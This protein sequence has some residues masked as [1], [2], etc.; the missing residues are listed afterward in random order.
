MRYVS[1]NPIP[2]WCAAVKVSNV[3]DDFVNNKD[4]PTAQAMMEYA[5]Q[6][7]MASCI[8]ISVNEKETTVIEWLKKNDLPKDLLWHTGGMVDT[9]RHCGTNRFPKNF[10]AS[11]T[12][13]RMK[14][15]MRRT[16]IEL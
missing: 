6:T 12:L 14:M 15:M 1:I 2:G 3:C 9:K 5:A 7:H 13:M 11:T 16:I 10:G 8:T 4:F